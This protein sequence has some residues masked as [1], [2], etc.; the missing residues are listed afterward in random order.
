MNPNQ[1]SWDEFMPQGRASARPEVRFYSELKHDEEASY[2]DGIPRF[3]LVDMIE[4][5]P[6]GGK[7]RRRV[8]V[9]D[10]H[11]VRFAPE[12]KRYEQH[13]EA[14]L[15]GTPLDYMTWL[16]PVRIAELKAQGIKTVEKLAEMPLELARRI[17][18]GMVRN[19][20]QARQLLA[21]PG[22]EVASLRRAVAALEH[23][24]EALKGQ[25]Q[26]L[27]QPVQTPR[28]EPQQVWMT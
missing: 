7:T 17:G 16:G 12:W 13:R 23:E 27:K 28:Q 3:Q 15:D 19:R 5:V 18:A 4:I 20:S 2:R 6:E 10:E 14:P 11:K 1:V 24:N 9:T 21:G 8:P 25:L 22:Q 26:A